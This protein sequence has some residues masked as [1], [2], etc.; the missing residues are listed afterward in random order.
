MIVILIIQKIAKTAVFNYHLL[1]HGLLSYFIISIFSETYDLL[2]HTYFMLFFICCL[3]Y[4]KKLFLLVMQIFM[5][6][7]FV[8]YKNEISMSRSI[9]LKISSYICFYDN[10]FT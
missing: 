3:C 6:F 5:E 2:F 4:S 1:K 10:N 8:L 9:I 7:N